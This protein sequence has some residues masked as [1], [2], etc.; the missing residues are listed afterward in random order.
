MKTARRHDIDWLRVITIALL[1]IYHIAIIFQPWAMFVGFIRSEQPLEGLWTP[2]SMLNV[3]RIP[4]L[5]FV[6]GMG[7]FF[8]MRKRNWKQLIGERARR[9]L[10]PL[11][12]GIV[13]IAPLHMFI[14]QKFPINTII[15]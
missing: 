3:W 8:A 14:F 7:L 10:L 1:L 9:I 13:A 15:I 12:F 6:S 11:L 5:F 4:I 2:M